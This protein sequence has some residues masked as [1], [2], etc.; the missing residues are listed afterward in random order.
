VSINPVFICSEARPQF[1]T[2]LSVIVTLFVIVTVSV[3]LTLFV[4]VTLSFY[5]IQ[6]GY[7]FSLWAQNFPSE[8]EPLMT[9]RA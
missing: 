5:D 1:L 9:E 6:F 3:I 8:H 4:I 2:L 7:E